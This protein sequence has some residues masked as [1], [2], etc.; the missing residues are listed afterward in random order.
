MGLA[1]KEIKPSQTEDITRLFGFSLA[2][3]LLL[4]GEKVLSPLV[5]GLI[6]L[7]I[8]FELHADS[9]SICHQGLCKQ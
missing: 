9:R 7:I 1:K 6:S 2:E 4:S 5:Y 8:R 3:L